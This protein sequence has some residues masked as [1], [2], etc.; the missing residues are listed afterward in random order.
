MSDID[1]DTTP[2]TLDQSHSVS[3]LPAP[4]ETAPSQGSTGA[5]DRVPPDTIAEASRTGTPVG[6]TATPTEPAEGD[7]QELPRDDVPPVGAIVPDDL[8]SEDVNVPD[9]DGPDEAVDARSGD[10]AQLRTSGL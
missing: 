1:R 3:D 7:L 5:A 2:T 9:L 6:P 10:T 8:P 4:R